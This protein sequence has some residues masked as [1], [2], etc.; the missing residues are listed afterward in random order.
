MAE[1]VSHSPIGPRVRQLREKHGWSLTELAERAEIS[2]SYLAQIERG[3]ST[4]TQ[5]K[6]IKLAGALG[7][8]PS[9]LLGEEP[10]ETEI[11][12]G[13]QNFAAQ[14][15]LP[16]AEIQMLAQIQYR[17]KRPSKPEEWK[18][19]YSLIKGLLEE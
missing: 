2:R 8:R 18:A 14:M 15:N 9:Q 12:E 5:E 17:G 16:P 3:G 10:E 6:I 4:P 7:V 11:P 13:L 1:K 19:I